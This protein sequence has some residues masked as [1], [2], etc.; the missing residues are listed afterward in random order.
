MYYLVLL[1][2]FVAFIYTGVRWQ[3]ER[4]RQLA[5]NSELNAQVGKRA[6]VTETVDDDHGL[7]RINGEAFAACCADGSDIGPRVMVEVLGVQRFRLLVRR[8]QGQ[9]QL[10]DVDEIINH[11]GEPS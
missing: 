5:V 6:I 10:I 9:G 7:V 8:I 2:I 1:A 3:R 11:D 4:G